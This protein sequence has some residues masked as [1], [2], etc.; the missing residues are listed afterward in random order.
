[1]IK[2]ADKL[3]EHSSRVLIRYK[4]MNALTFAFYKDRMFQVEGC[5]A[6]NW[7][8]EFEVDEWISISDLNTLLE[9]EQTK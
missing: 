5:T 6:S 7:I 1:M 4:E 3:P 9:K 8:H 2:I